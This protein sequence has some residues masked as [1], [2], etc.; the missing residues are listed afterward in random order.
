MRRCL[1]TSES[2]ATEKR[3][4]RRLP[5]R[6]PLVCRDPDSPGRV[7]VRS[8]TANVST[9]GL[10]FETLADGIQV[11]QAFELELTI[12]PGDGHFPYQGRVAAQAEVVRVD[13]LPP[14]PEG[15]GI[16]QLSRWGVAARFNANLKLSF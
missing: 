15:E 12:P 7:L 14:T 9:G 1:P 10:Y 13:E 11:G 6:L 2:M 16:M 8:K 5:I 3:Q 4:H